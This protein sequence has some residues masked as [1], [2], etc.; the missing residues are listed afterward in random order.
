M[1]FIQLF[2]GIMWAFSP[3]ARFT[4]SPQRQIRDDAARI[5]ARVRV[6]RGRAG[7][8]PDC[9]AYLHRA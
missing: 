6:R 5:L 3:G 4:A 7:Y 1:E 2:T 8:W 9:V